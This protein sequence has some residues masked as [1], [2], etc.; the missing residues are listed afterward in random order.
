MT[1]E[2][3]WTPLYTLDIPEHEMTSRHLPFDT[4]KCKFPE[5]CQ[6]VWVTVKPAEGGLLFVD[7][8][9]FYCREDGTRYFRCETS[10]PTNQEI[11]A[12]APFVRPKPYGGT[13][14]SE[15]T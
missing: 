10:V 13:D 7:K 8:A 5:D 2:Y 9:M 4:S 12:W 3:W 11:I 1:I 14:E 15:D 6:T